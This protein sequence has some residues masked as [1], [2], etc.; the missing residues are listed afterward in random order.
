MNLLTW[1]IYGS[2]FTS[3][4]DSR[5]ISPKLNE[6]LF[7]GFVTIEQSCSLHKKSKHLDPELVFKIYWSQFDNREK[8][9]KLIVSKSP[10]FL[11]CLSVCFGSVQQYSLASVDSAE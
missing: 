9:T 10:L 2:H 1:D 6:W 4:L 7:H 5:L 11:I 8:L 3:L